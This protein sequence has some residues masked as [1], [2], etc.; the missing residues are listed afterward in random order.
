MRLLALTVCGLCFSWTSSTFA[1]EGCNKNSVVTKDI[2]ECANTSYKKIDKKLNEQYSMLIADPAFINRNI[3]LEG[4]R[5]W[6]KYRDVYCTNV[7]ESILPGEEAGVERVACLI[8][9]TSSRL[10]ELLYLAT[11]V[12]TDGFYNSLSIMN[13]AA[14][15]TREEVFLYI[16]SVDKYPEEIEYY[17]KNCELT[18]VIHAED[19]RTCRAR[20]KFQAM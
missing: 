7:Y 13:T 16:E 2:L 4:E 3:L 8:S 18:N 19:E 5:A 10:V 12:T 17:K 15:M 9:L 1:D 20:M 14:S 11:G 6:V